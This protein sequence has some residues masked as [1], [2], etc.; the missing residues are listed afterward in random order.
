MAGAPRFKTTSQIPLSRKRQIIAL[1]DSISRE[2]PE[3]L[4]HIAHWQQKELCFLRMYLQK[5]IQKGTK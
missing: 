3:L 1:A 5:K 2:H 4:A